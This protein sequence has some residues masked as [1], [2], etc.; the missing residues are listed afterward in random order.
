M[1]GAP[2][3]QV[4]CDE[5]LIHA[6]AYGLHA[7]SAVPTVDSTARAL[8]LVAVQTKAAAGTVTVLMPS[9]AR[10]GP[11]GALIVPQVSVGS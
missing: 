9:I 5:S 11:S 1:C 8:T 10:N 4:A 7:V 2:R 3:N 6:L